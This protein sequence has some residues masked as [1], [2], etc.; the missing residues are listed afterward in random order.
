MSLRPNSWWSRLLLIFCTYVISAALL[1]IAL[2]VLINAIG[3]L[4]YSDRPGPGWQAPH[5]PSIQE[6]H[7]FFGFAVLV[8][9]ATALYGV[10]FATAAVV[11]AFCRLPR[12]ALRILATPT[13][14]LSAGL[15][16][17]AAG[18]LIA[19]SEVG[20]FTAAVCGA[21][22]GLLVFPRLV[23][24]VPHVLPM[25]LRVALPTILFAGS[26]YL[27]VSPFLPNPSLT[28]AKIE[29]IQRDDRGVGIDQVGLGFLGPTVAPQAQGTHKYVSLVRMEFTT[30]TRNHTSVLLI[31]DDS[32]PVAHTFLLPRSGNAIYRQSRG[33]WQ[34]ERF[35][36][37]SSELSVELTRT[38]SGGINLQPRG[39]CC[40][41]MAQ[42]SPPYR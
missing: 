41:S 36:G 2:L 23:P 1:P 21:F 24:V 6:L 30:D 3:Y 14:F 22:W 7:F 4:P 40:S 16:M 28:N 11:L 35:E 17:A 15:M 13:A 33:E 5:L 8:S 18:W 26:G 42:T 12:W 39:S 29:V 34:R 31:V 20:V 37:Q 27:L 25:A 9:K 32:Q 10:G 19:I 38:P